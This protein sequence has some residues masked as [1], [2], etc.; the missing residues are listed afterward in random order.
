MKKIYILSAAA[1]LSGFSLKTSAQCNPSIPSQAIAVT[2]SDTFFIG[3]EKIWGCP[4]S[5]IIDNGSADTAFLETNCTYTSNGGDVVIFAKSGC[6]IN[7]YGDG[8]II[9]KEPGVTVNDISMGA[10]INNCSSILFNYANAPASGCAMSA[11]AQISTVVVT[12]LPNPVSKSL[13]FSLKG[14]DFS[15]VIIEIFELTGQPV[16]TI[17]PDNAQYT[18]DVSAFKEGIYFYKVISKEKIVKSE[19]F[20]VLKK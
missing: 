1:L 20:V 8:E 2:V 14:I 16:M 17:K 13:T 19:K 6:V 18:I 11:D 10:T 15:K 7:C 4:G 3:D 5:V 12:A 9:Y